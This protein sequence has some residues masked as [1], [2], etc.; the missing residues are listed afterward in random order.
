VLNAAAAAVAAAAPPAA[1]G[2]SIMAAFKRAEGRQGVKCCPVCSMDF[3]AEMSNNE[4]RLHID[5]C[6]ATIDEDF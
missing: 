4:V 5:G 6:L 2:G 1:V 3:S